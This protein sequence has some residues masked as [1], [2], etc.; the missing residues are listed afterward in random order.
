MKIRIILL[1]LAFIITT[2]II[3]GQTDTLITGL[4]SLTDNSGNQHLFYRISYRNIENAVD[5]QRSDIYHLSVNDQSDSL[6]LKSYT[7]K[8]LNS[9]NDSKLEIS[10]IVDYEFINNDISKTLFV[11]KTES[12]SAVWQIHRKDIGKTFSSN[13]PIHSLELGNQEDNTVY[14]NCGGKIIRSTDN[15]SSWSNPNDTTAYNRDFNLLS[16]SPF[17]E[18]VIFGVD[19]DNN[20]IKSTDSGKTSV[21]VDNSL[22]WKPG[23]EF[24]Y[25]S[26]ENHIYSVNN[27]G[28]L[29]SLMISG[30]SGD[31]YTWQS[32]KTDSGKISVTTSNLEDGL[33]YYSHHKR[34]YKSVDYGGTFENYLS[35]ENRVNNLTTLNDSNLPVYAS[36]Y[37]IARWENDRL[38][39]FKRTSKQNSLKYYPLEIGNKW[40]YYDKIEK[41]VGDTVFSEGRHYKIIEVK[42]LNSSNDYT[43]YKFARIDTATGYLHWFGDSYEIYIDLTAMKNDM[44]YPP[45]DSDINGFSVCRNF[46]TTYLFGK[47]RFKKVF[48]QHILHTPEYRFVQGIG[49]Q[50][51]DYRYDFGYGMEKL[52]GAVINGKVYGDT[53]IVSVK[54]S[55]EEQTP[56]K[57]RLSQ[58]Y[59]NPFNPETKIKYTVG[60]IADLSGNET[61]LTLKVYDILGRKVKTLVNKHQ[62]PGTYEITFDAGDLPSGVYFYRLKA[63]DFADSRKMILMR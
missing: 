32:V 19:E 15:G 56:K 36:S 47:Y 3:N 52:K 43:N 51:M 9:P 1:I 7:V 63:R 34:I 28:G 4:K 44:L 41:V 8:N 20:L 25:G 50:R 29:Y 22:N 30:S 40:I 33:V 11:V 53:T 37:K 57:F 16:V 27:D 49:M 39:V 42:H 12:D 55:S 13:L 24:V 18:S 54:E 14:A 23:A 45:Q 60:Q 35:T 10:E 59:P 46:D 61:Q 58:N 2:G 26:D 5:T 6:F 31:P 21:I 38:H 17:D 48:K 62:K